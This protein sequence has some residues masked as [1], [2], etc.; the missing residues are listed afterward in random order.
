MALILRGIDNLD[1]A[2]IVKDSTCESDIAPY[3]KGFKNYIIN[4]NFDIWQRGTSGFSGQNYGADRW[5]G[6]T[7]VES[8]SRQ[9]VDSLG[10]YYARIS[11]TTASSSA[12]LL[13]QRIE[14]SN[15]KDLAGKIMT[16]SF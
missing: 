9:N 8:Y 6:S 15:V 4:G 13:V 16:L 7:G 14:Q 1:S 3:N 12:L 2:D 10:G 5:I 11:R